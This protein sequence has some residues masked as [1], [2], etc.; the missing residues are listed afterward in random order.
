MT[1]VKIVSFYTDGRY[2]RESLRLSR[3]LNR[4]YYE[5]V[6][7]D[8]PSWQQAVAHKPQFILDVLERLENDDGLLWADADSELVRDP[9]W[10]ELSGCDFAAVWFKRGPNWAEEILTGMLYFSKNERMLQFVR[11]WV[12]VTPNYAGRDCP[13]QEALK[14]V[15]ARP[16]SLSVKRLSPEWCWIKDDSESIYGQK[17]AI[18]FQHQASRRFR[19]GERENLPIIGKKEGF[20]EKVEA[21]QPPMV[22]DTGYIPYSQ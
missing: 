22:R 17:E 5:I 8:L 14:E 16:H 13:E 2:Y 15:L 1:T 4:H 9:D 3:S 10:S 12:K 19:F 20:S 18:F 21:F 7:V 6:Y 11:D